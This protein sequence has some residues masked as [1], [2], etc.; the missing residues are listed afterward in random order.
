MLPIADI[1][2][3]SWNLYIAKFKKYLPVLGIIFVV[4]AIMEIADILAIDV[5]HLADIWKTTILIATGILTY[6]L[7]FI[8]TIILIILSNKLLDNKKGAVSI[9]EIKDVFLHA[10]LVAVVVALITA[11]GFLL[12][13]V[14]GVLFMVWYAFAMYLVILE[15][16]SGI[17]LLAESRELSRG[18][19]W[20]VFGRLVVPSVFWAIISYLV[21]AGIF[22]VLGLVLN[23]AF[24]VSQTS[25]ILEIAS[26]LISN[27]VAAFFAPLYI[28]VATIVYRAV[29]K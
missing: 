22:S 1:I 10:F 16:K 18:K 9:K 12:L 28:I 3:Q 19:F 25:L 13:I 5:F 2:R 20:A 7:T 4:T 29:K 24:G 17:K 14:P 8:I 21:L 26:S 6:F 27:L 15:K 23:K 11:G